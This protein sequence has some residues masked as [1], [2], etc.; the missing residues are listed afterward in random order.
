MPQ[1]TNCPQK[2]S[3]LNVGD[4]CTNCYKK[5]TDGTSDS[6]DTQKRTS[7]AIAGIPLSNIQDIP[8]LTEKDMDQP[9]T[10]ATMLKMLA[11]AIKPIHQRID[12]H[13]KRIS[14][15]EEGQNNNSATIKKV[16]DECKNVSNR[17][18]SSETK[19][20]NLE[21]ANDKLKKVVVKQQSHIANQDKKERLRNVVIAGLSESEPLTSGGPTTDREKIDHIL[22]NLNIQHVDVV[23]CRRTGNKDQGPQDRPRFLIVELKTQAMRNE[24]KYAGPKLNSIEHLKNIRIKADLNKAERTEYKRIYDLKDKLQLENPNDTVQVNK[25]VLTL[26]GTQIDKF[27]NPSMDF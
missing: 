16:D 7:F 25:G 23:N 12:E 22:E 13:E 17:L 21:A 18:T 15:L 19:I 6:H 5:E 4:L 26:N 14:K 9:I 24:L 11:D 20:K 27:K 1:C 2:Q 10:A 3:R 8:D